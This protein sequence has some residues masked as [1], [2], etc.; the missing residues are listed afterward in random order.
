MVEDRGYSIM[1]DRKVQ[2][3]KEPI[4][5]CQHMLDGLSLL[6]ANPASEVG[7]LSTSFIVCASFL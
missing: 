6:I 2:G 3:D 1:A 5:A 4:T 7:V